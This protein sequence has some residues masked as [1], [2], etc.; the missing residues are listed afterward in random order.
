MSKKITIKTT[1]L[2]Q[3]SIDKPAEM[4]K[5][6]T[7]LKQHIIKHELFTNIVGKNYVH[8][9]G[10]AFAGSL[11]GMYPRI[12]S[13]EC[14]SNGSEVKWRAN[15]SIYHGDK[16]VSTGIAIC[17]NKEG[18]KSKFDEYAILSM[19]QT[20]AIG[21]AYR[22]LIGWV[23]KLAG[24]E[25]TPAEEMA[26]GGAVPTSAPVTPEITQNNAPQAKKEGQVKD[27][28]GNWTYLC[29]KCDAPISEAGANLSFKMT[30]KR[31]CR[32]HYNEAKKK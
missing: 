19:A 30:G 5:M 1:D 9:D 28:D 21:K 7:V 14:L 15:V 32:E 3:Y 17:S 25:G 27:P 10:W 31:L 26:K 6:A 24:Y 20:R 2:K 8:V 22:N 4:T 16:V 18:K 12:D 29:K 11:M 23:I 13:V